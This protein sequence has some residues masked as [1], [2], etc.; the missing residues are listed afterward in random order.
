MAQDIGLSAK[1]DTRQF[2]RG[3][4]T[5]VAGLKKAESETARTAA[6]INASALQIANAWKQASAAP[7]VALLALQRL[8][9]S[10]QQLGNTVLAAGQGLNQF[11]LAF[12]GLAAATN[13][14]TGN[15]TRLG[16]TYAK[17][18]ASLS[19]MRSKLS[20]VTNA[21]LATAAAL[22][23]VLVLALRRIGFAIRGVIQ[24][25]IELVT[26][27]ERAQLALN[28][29]A[30]RSLRATNASLELG[31]ALAQTRTESKGLLIW[32]QKVAILS[33]FTSKDVVQAFRVSQAY[34]LLADD[35]KVL[36]PLLL[37]MGAAI[38]LDPQTLE[39]AARALGQ[40]QA[41][42]KLTGEEIRQLGNAGIPIRDILVKQLGIAASEF[43]PLLEA[44]K[45]TASVTI[46]AIVTAL[47]EFEGAGERV[48]FETIGGMLSAFAELKQVGTARFFEGIFEPLRE[49]MLNLIEAAN[50]LETI[51]WFRVLGEEVGNFIKSSVLRLVNGIK[52]LI[53]TWKNLDPEIKQVIV[54]FATSVVV[55]TGVALALGAV[56]LAARLIIRPFTLIILALAAV[57]TAWQ[58]NIGNFQSG[59]KGILSSLGELGSGV[60]TITSSIINAFGNMFVGIGELFS[61]FVDEVGNWGEAIIDVFAIGLSVL[62]P[63][64]TALAVMREV[65]QYWLKPGSPSRV[66]GPVDR[67]GEETIDVFGDGLRLGIEKLHIPLLGISNVMEESTKG[68]ARDANLASVGEDAAN[69]VTDGW[70]KA[71]D[72]DAEIA[73]ASMQGYFYDIQKDTESRVEPIMEETG[74]DVAAAFWDGFIQEF[75]KPIRQ[76]NQA[77]QDALSQLG[78]GRQLDTS[79]ALAIEKYLEGFKKADFSALDQISG[80]VSS[81]LSSLAKIGELG[82]L[83]VPRTLS[84]TRKALAKAIDEFREFGRVGEGTLSAVRNAAGPAGRAT[85]EYFNKYIEFAVAADAATAAQDSLNT[86]VEYYKNLITP[87]REELEA[88]QRQTTEFSE[89]REIVRLTRVTK[90]FAFSELRRREAQAKID[91]IHAGARLRNLEGEEK[92]A[93]EVGNAQLTEA[94]KIEDELSTQLGLMTSRFNL[95]NKQLTAVSQEASIIEKLNKELE[96]LRKKEESDLELQLKFAKLLNEEERDRLEEARARHVLNSADSTEYQRQQAF[97]KLQTIELN[98]QR[99]ELEAVKLGFDPAAFQPIRDSIITLDDLG[100]KTKDTASDFEEMFDK[101]GVAGD[102][103]LGFQAEWEAAIEKVR[104]KYAEVETQIGST[105]AAIND[106]LPKFLA[107]FPE[108]EG[109]DPPIITNLKKMSTAIWA[110]GAAFVGSSLLLRLAALKEAMIL[111]GIPSLLTGIANVFGG[112]IRWLL[113][114]GGAVGFLTAAITVGVLSWTTNFLEFRDRVSRILGSVVRNMFGF[115]EILIN[116]ARIANNLRKLITTGEGRQELVDTF[117]QLSSDFEKEG[118]G[119]IFGDIDFAESGRDAATNFFEGASEGVVFNPF[120]GLLNVFNEQIAD[121]ASGVDT[122]TFTS[123]TV[124]KLNEDML[125]ESDRV[126][127]SFA[128]LFSSQEFEQKAIVEAGKAGQALSQGAINGLILDKVEAEDKV[129]TWANGVIDVFK[130]FFRIKSPSALMATE[131]GEPIGKGIIDGITTFLNKEGSSDAVAN[132]FGNIE[133]EAK[134]STGNILTNAKTFNTIFKIR[135]K[136]LTG[137]VGDAWEFVTTS[138]V[139]SWNAIKAHILSIIEE[140][141]N[142]LPELMKPLIDVVVGIFKQMRQGVDTEVSGMVKDVEGS[143]VTNEDSMLAILQDAL[144]GTTSPGGIS[145]KDGAGYLLGIGF[146][147]G[148][149]LGINDP[150][151]WTTVVLPAITTWITN[152]TKAWETGLGID[153]PSRVAAESIGIPFAEGIA[154]GIAKGQ[155]LIS[156]AVS[157]AMNS[158]LGGILNSQYGSSSAASSS[159]VTNNV[160]RSFAYNLNVNTPAASQGVINDFA[161]MRVLAAS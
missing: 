12:V 13:N 33:P 43:D 124:D 142:E 75:P 159:N 131:I 85:V 64:Y 150:T 111:L 4:N 25:G 120:A 71:L 15:L 39:N 67:W 97:L 59:T 28:F 157:N 81:R 27:F 92:A 53:N 93:T 32:L 41:R 84:D 123:I 143:I 36:V 31:D 48:A 49:G 113:V 7:S 14:L 122:E 34:G 1:F 127:G 58:M 42:G 21:S 66:S 161:I 5:Y 95:Q 136:A 141:T 10:I 68:A 47:R 133:M 62:N 50:D 154:L 108:E 152:W 158:S 3:L 87:I 107:L 101:I 80:I 116:M 40:I 140:L 20:G 45:I 151:T 16:A 37:D 128:N 147:T 129:T 104:K 29:F 103:A 153:S 61:A 11:T 74:G 137:I 51:A 69:E 99:R 63:I 8:S 44:G 112:A 94:K 119:A 91:Q 70:L 89:Q 98:R 22:G 135:M 54:T 77:I 125:K 115:V 6:A 155:P 105:L 72:L 73:K 90:N 2:T 35:A 117:K 156:G 19:Q 18:N 86:T 9:A 134:E 38:G 26:F 17:H 52:N 55:F 106:S 109:G 110:V 24:E 149:A 160:N 138:T 30:A 23:T 148:I 114:L 88:L 78:G 121:V 46:P 79:G 57:N 83:D 82:D 56:A 96:R 60:A 145:N 130:N 144:V 126:A 139:D 102:D 118:F 146:V 76:I 132:T 65:F 100:I